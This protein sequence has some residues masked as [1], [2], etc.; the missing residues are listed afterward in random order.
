MGVFCRLKDTFVKWCKKKKNGK[1]MGQFSGTHVLSCELLGQFSS[2]L[3]CRFVYMESIQYVNLIE[4]G[5]VVIEILDV[6]NDELAVPVNNTLVHH[7]A[8]LVTDT[9]PG[10]LM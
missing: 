10:V 3:V 5:S 2:N 1:K 6:E 9:R 7:T 8:F 4:I